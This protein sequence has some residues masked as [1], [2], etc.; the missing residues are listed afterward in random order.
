MNSN[1]C[2]KLPWGTFK[3]I[4]NPMNLNRKRTE[5][6]CFTASVFILQMSSGGLVLPA[7][8]KELR[9]QKIRQTLGPTQT[10]ELHTKLEK[11]VPRERHNKSYTRG[12]GGWE[13]GEWGDRRGMCGAT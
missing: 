9:D 11:G 8:T 5:A 2:R 13:R 4:S 12:K 1:K 6:Y 10:R 3:S 7:L